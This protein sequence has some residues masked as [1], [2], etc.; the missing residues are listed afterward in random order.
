MISGSDAPGASAGPNA[1]SDLSRGFGEPA[2]VLSSAP[3]ASGDGTPELGSY[4]NNSTLFK[5]VIES[6]RSIGID[7]KFEGEIHSQA[8]VVIGRDAEVKGNIF[9]ET[10]IVAG[11]VMGN[12]NSSM[13]ELQ[14]TAHLLGNVRTGSLLVGLG[15]IFKGQCNMG[16]EEAQAEVE[17]MARSDTE[18]A[19]EPAAEQPLHAG[20]SRRRRG[21]EPEAAAEEPAEEAEAS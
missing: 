7:G 19:V 2:S 9:G 14:A 13:L 11:K 6:S 5:G 21:N 20:S 17:S 16:S 3:A 1:G 8:D 15:A 18:S 12:V 4:V 10:V